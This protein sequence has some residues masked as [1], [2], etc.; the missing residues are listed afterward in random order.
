MYQIELCLLP[1]WGS[2]GHL[3]W[4]KLALSN[5]PGVNPSSPAW[6]R[7][8]FSYLLWPRPLPMAWHLPENNPGALSAKSSTAK[9]YFLLIEAE[10]IERA[11]HLFI[12]HR[13]QWWAIFLTSTM[14]SFQLEWAAVVGRTVSWVP[15]NVGIC[16]KPMGRYL[17]CLWDCL[18]E[19]G[20]N[21]GKASV[22]WFQ[23]WTWC[24]YD[25]L[26]KYP[27]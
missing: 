26:M 16:P 18:S 24:F 4:R 14:P 23:V 2:R 3:S 9:T 19:W 20:G 7:L 13:G 27:L 6:H 21:W 25:Y 8:L 22:R 1:G 5:K 11:F 12:G 17:P 10:R 15:G